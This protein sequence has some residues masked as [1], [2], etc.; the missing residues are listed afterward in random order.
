MSAPVFLNL[1]NK[2][3]KRDKMQGLTSIYHFIATNL[4]NSI[5][6]KHECRFYLLKGVYMTLKLHF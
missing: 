2:L 3:R 5:I 1:L 6:Q 4:M